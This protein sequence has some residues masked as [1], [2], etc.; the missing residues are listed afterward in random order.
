[1]VSKQASLQQ[2]SGGGK[3]ARRSAQRACAR[4]ERQRLTAGADTR[5]SIGVV[6]DTCGD[7]GDVAPSRRLLRLARRAL[8]T[9]C[10]S[11]P[12]APSESFLLMA[13]RASSPKKAPRAARERSISKRRIAAMSLLCERSSRG[14]PHR[15][16]MAIWK[17]QKRRVKGTALTSSTTHVDVLS[18]T[19]QLM[20]SL[21]IRS[22]RRERRQ[23]LNCKTHRHPHVI[24]AKKR[25]SISF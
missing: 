20:A 19:A 14:R 10:T 2:A 4:R 11:T 24:G 5:F 16:A 8:E 1:M 17:R 3:A 15:S 22:L 21:S 25:L 13:G 9:S 18:W 6:R 7:A 23:P 12:P